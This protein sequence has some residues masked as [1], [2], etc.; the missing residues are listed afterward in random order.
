MMLVLGELMFCTPG[1]ATITVFGFDDLGDD[2]SRHRW[3]AHWA[4]G[5]LANEVSGIY[6][7]AYPVVR[8]TKKGAW[9]DTL[10]YRQA[11]KQPWEDGAPSLEWVIS[12]SKSAHRFIVDGSGSSWAKPTRDDAIRSIAIRLERWTRKLAN[13]HKRAMSAVLGLRHVRPDLEHFSLRAEANLKEVSS[14][15]SSI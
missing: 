13:E 10:S 15:W 2:P 1:P 11:T 3:R 5:D 12:E 7:Q 14:T 9:I 4:P 6:L 8:L